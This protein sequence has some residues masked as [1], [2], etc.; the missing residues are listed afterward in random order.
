VD[1]TRDNIVSNLIVIDYNIFR[2]KYKLAFAYTE[3]AL[4][5]RLHKA[6]TILTENDRFLCQ[7][8]ISEQA[9]MSLVDNIVKEKHPKVTI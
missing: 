5:E 6:I 4:I 9:E 2:R 1:R 7:E 3:N 8:S